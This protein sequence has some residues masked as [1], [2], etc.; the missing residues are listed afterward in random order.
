MITIGVEVG[1]VL[2]LLIK[3]QVLGERFRILRVINYTML[4]QVAQEAFYLG[5]IWIC[6]T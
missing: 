4:Y 5:L 3:M 2:K 6:L 1:S